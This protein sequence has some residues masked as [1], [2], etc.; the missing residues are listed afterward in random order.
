MG[1]KSGLGEKGT[2]AERLPFKKHNLSCR[3]INAPRPVENFSAYFPPT[4]IHHHMHSRGR[5][6]ALRCIKVHKNLELSVVI[7]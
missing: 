5:G 3:D 7:F 2:E 4:E 6:P 1:L